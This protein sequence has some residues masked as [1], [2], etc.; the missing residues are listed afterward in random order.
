MKQLKIDSL[1]SGI[2]YRL[3]S[4]DCHDYISYGT[5]S[6]VC[7]NRVYLGPNE[8]KYKIRELCTNWVTDTI[9]TIRIATKEE[10]SYLD[11][12][13]AKGSIV[14]PISDFNKIETNIINDSYEI[15]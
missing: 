11:D 9:W 14:L 5:N 1:K 6:L 15:F 7:G 13:I 2:C 3:I 8:L 10:Q 4:K 12:C